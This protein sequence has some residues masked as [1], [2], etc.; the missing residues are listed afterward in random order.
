MFGAKRSTVFSWVMAAAMTLGGVAQASEPGVVPPQEPSAADESRL[1]AG[2]AL[3]TQE[4]VLHLKV[5]D[6]ASRGQSLSTMTQS[7]T[8][9]VDVTVVGLNGGGAVVGSPVGGVTSMDLPAYSG[10]GSAPRAMLRVT[11]R[12][13][14][15]SLSPG[16]ADFE[17]GADF[18]KDARSSGSSRDN[19]DNLIQR[20]LFSDVSQYKIDIDRGRPACRVKGS[21]GSVHARS[22]VVTKAT[23][24]YRVRCVREGEGLRFVVLETRADGSTSRTEIKKQGAIGAVTWP[25]TQRRP[26][27][28]GGKLLAKGSIVASST[29]QFNG[30][31]S[32]PIVVVRP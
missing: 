18:V 21:K 9:A 32:F 29:D 8:A 31:V 1:A 26:L 12:S 20:G 30:R 15:T 10:S 27:S 28:V 24:S 14:D 17:F 16:W 6:G 2:A 3:G 7:G 11:P 4:W 5:P 25:A 13:T 19:G 22:N 23:S